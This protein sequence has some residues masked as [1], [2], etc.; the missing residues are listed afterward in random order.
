M[1]YLERTEPVSVGVS[2]MLDENSFVAPAVVDAIRTAIVNQAIDVGVQ[3]VKNA[4]TSIKS[5]AQKLAK[6]LNE[7]N[8]ERTTEQHDR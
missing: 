4:V 6:R 2:L 8:G 1:Q 5:R 3:K 7:L